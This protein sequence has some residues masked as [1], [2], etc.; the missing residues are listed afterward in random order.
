MNVQNHSKPFKKR[1]R[2]TLSS[3]VENIE[4]T[5]PF[6]SARQ[7]LE[8]ILP[9]EIIDMVEDSQLPMLRFGKPLSPLVVIKANGIRAAKSARTTDPMWYAVAGDRPLRYVVPPSKTCVQW[10]FHIP[11]RMMGYASIGIVAPIEKTDLNGP[12]PFDYA[13][14]KMWGFQISSWKFWHGCCWM[15]ASECS[16]VDRA[17]FGGQ[18]HTV[19]VQ[20]RL[21]FDTGNFYIG[22]NGENMSLI[23]TLEKSDAI[24]VCPYVCFSLEPASVDIEQLE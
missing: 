19:V 24:L 6:V 4:E 2:E 9:P 8:L 21:E 11:R 10:R 18:N 3:G 7:C 20:C 17:H 14:Q 23:T 1:R 13:F 12:E 5:S 16:R 22:E 15:H